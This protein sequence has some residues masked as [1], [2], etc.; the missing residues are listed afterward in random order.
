MNQEYNEAINKLITLSRNAS[1]A[2]NS[3]HYAKAAKDVAQAAYLLALAE[4]K[5]FTNSTQ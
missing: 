2:E 4:E 5:H 1:T 3:A